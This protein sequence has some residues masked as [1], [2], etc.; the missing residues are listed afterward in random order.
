MVFCLSCARFKEL[1]PSKSDKKLCLIHATKI[2][3][4][5]RGSSMLML[6]SDTNIKMKGFGKRKTAIVNNYVTSRP[7][8]INHYDLD[9]QVFL[10]CLYF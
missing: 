7:S 5:N 4:K 3:E 9:S 1:V 10:L 8:L 2:R 6:M